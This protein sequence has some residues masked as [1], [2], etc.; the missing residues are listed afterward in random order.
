MS[1]MT[2]V[3]PTED[4]I[5]VEPMKHKET[6]RRGLYIPATQDDR[7]QQGTV[8]ATG[9]GSLDQNG[10]LRKVRVLAGARVLY[11]KYAGT[12]VVVDGVE[13]LIINEGDILAVIDD[14]REID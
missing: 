11:G 8:I 9:P 12:E 7:P 5:L 10:R 1:S 14:V 3:Q 13:Y 2:T 6:M 4:R